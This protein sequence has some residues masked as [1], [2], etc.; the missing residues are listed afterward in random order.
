[1]ALERT[2]YADVITQVGGYYNFVTLINRRLK[3]LRNGDHPMV[4]TQP[5][6][7]EIDIVVREIEAGLLVLHVAAE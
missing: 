3:E 6:E 4:E 7:D 2:Q 5:R 1:M